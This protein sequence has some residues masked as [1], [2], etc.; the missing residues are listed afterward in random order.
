MMTTRRNNP[1]FLLC[2][3]VGKGFDLKFVEGQCTDSVMVFIV[4]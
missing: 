4:N 1:V 3:L 2:F